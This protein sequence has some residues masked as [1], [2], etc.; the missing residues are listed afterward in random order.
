[1]RPQRLI[2]SPG[3]PGGIGGEILVDA[4]Y[5]GASPLV[6]IDDPDRLSA[7]AKA[8]KL[9]LKIAVVDDLDAADGLSSDTLAVLPITWAETPKPGHAS[10]ANAPQVIEA[11]RK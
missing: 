8:K 4:A 10:V 6:T 5:H 11:I 2:V 9:P 3:E 7:I 1:M